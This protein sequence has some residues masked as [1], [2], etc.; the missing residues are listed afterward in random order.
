MIG[1]GGQGVVF[2]KNG[3]AIKTSL[4][5]NKADI[6]KEY[7][8]LYQINQRLP[9]HSNIVKVFEYWDGYFSMEYLGDMCRS[10]AKT[11][12]FSLLMKNGGF[13]KSWQAQ[14]MTCIM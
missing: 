9:E 14:S 1:N 7:R 13:T 12:L 6:Y 11:C 3:M 2:Q 4:S 5:G 8:H 10:A